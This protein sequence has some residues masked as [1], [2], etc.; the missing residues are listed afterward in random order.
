MGVR[1]ESCFLSGDS[2]CGKGWQ[3]DECGSHS[4]LLLSPGFVSLSLVLSLPTSAPLVISTFVFIRMLRIQIK[5][6][7]QSD[8]HSDD[9]HHC[10]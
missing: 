4:V 8:L 2:G 6:T 7:T 3:L 1:K 9:I 5:A 10:T